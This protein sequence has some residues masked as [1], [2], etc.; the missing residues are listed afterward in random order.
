M[1]DTPA[2]IWNF[3]E[4]G[5]GSLTT[6]SHVNDYDFIWAIESDNLKIE[7]SW[8]YTLNDEYEYELNQKEKT[9]ILTSGKKTYALF[10]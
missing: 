9:L 6:N 8:L 3:K 5:K 2:V 1:K 7:T 10:D 4:I